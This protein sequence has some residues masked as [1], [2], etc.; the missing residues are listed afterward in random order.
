MPKVVTVFFYFIKELIFDSKYGPKTKKEVS[1]W[2]MVMLFTVCTCVAAAA[3]FFERSWELAQANIEYHAKIRQLE[4]EIEL[5]KEDSK[6][7]KATI[8]L[9]Q[10]HLYPKSQALPPLKKSKITE[11]KNN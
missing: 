1:K 8:M 9:L 11:A 4:E 3:F 10:F 6:V 7:D 5:L 2:R